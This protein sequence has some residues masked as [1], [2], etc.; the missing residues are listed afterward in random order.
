MNVIDL[1]YQ[2]QVASQ[3]DYEHQGVYKNHI[4]QLF[5]IAD[6]YTVDIEQIGNI[7]MSWERYHNNTCWCNVVIG[8]HSMQDAMDD[9]IGTINDMVYPS[10]R[11]DV[12]TFRLALLYEKT[13]VPYE[14]YIHWT[15][16]KYIHI[17]LR[18][19]EPEGV[20]NVL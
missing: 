6:D 12:D 4:T 9:G 3:Y 7:E 13:N 1:L 17:K 18:K 19:I 20:N 16:R 10:M 2:E 14:L 11:V 5:D 15:K 8:Q